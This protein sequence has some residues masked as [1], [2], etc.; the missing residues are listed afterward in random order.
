MGNYNYYVAWEQRILYKNV[1]KLNM[2][3]LILQCVL[4][5]VGLTMVLGS[6]V[7]LTEMSTRNISWRLRRTVRRND[8]LATFMCRLS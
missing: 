4:T 2:S 7:P 1:Q 3:L 8:N 5:L 6:T